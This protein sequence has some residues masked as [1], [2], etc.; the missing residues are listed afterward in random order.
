VGPF[1]AH[2]IEVRNEIVTYKGRTYPLQP[3][4]FG[5]DIV[6][7]EMGISDNH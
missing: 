7:D 4:V 1:S 6:E 2:D 3:V 5:V